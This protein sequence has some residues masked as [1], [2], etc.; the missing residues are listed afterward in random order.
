MP[1][2]TP[3][4]DLDQG[5][6]QREAIKGKRVARSPEPG[7]PGG[8]EDRPDDPRREERM[9][10]RILDASIFFVCVCWIAATAAVIGSAAA[11][12]PRMQRVRVREGH[13]GR[14]G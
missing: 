6:A 9:D 10:P 8:G 7:T 14:R 11:A 12:K 1:S 5:G 4:V 13:H 3:G 2:G